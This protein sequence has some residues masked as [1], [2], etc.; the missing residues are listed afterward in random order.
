MCLDNV[1]CCSYT[2]CFNQFKHIFCASIHMH[3]VNGVCADRMCVLYKKDSRQ[4]HC[5]PGESVPG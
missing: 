5:N 4:E 1:N 3:N 2:K